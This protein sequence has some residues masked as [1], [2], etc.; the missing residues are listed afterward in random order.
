MDFLVVILKS[1]CRLNSFSST[2]VPLHDLWPYSVISE[3]QLN[4]SLETG[5][6]E[7]GLVL[8]LLQPTHLF[9]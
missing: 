7:L 1:Y 8:Q 4:I 6:G 2:H 5:P 9:Q 3:K